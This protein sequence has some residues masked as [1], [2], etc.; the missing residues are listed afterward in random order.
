MKKLSF[1]NV[2]GVLLT[3]LVAALFLNGC[4]EPEGIR[5]YTVAK[6]KNEKR[7]ELPAA[8]TA[9]ADSGPPTD[10]MLG[11]IVPVGDQTWYFKVTGPLA[12]IEKQA[13]AIQKFFGTITVAGGEAKP[14]W[15]KPADW[16][17]HGPSGMRAATLDIPAEPKPLELTVIALPTTGAPNELLDNVNRWRGQMQLPPTDAAALA[18]TVKES[19]AGEA[20]MHIVDLTGKSSGGM[21]AP[22][23]GGGA[24]PPNAPFAGGAGRPPGDPG[25]VANPNATDLPPGHPPITGGAAVDP[26]TAAPLTFDAPASW[27]QQPAMG[28]RKASFQIQDGDRKAEVTAIDLAASAPSIADPLQNVNRWRTTELGLPP[29]TAEQ[30]PALIQKIEVGG[31]PA[32]YVELI[33]DM[34]NPAESQAKEATFAAT[35]PAGRMIWF[36]KLRGHRDL[37][38]AERDNFKAFLNSIRFTSDGGAG[39][40]N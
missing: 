19:K 7:Q 9:P 3:F 2:S 6:E 11:A 28:M 30:L 23:A 8:T 18:A 13:E 34:S 20:T 24:A 10:R 36:F 16:Q 35:V 37:V 27:K 17:E 5:T 29:I 39:N 14:T 4:S 15:E 25:A 40:G 33:P 22:F 1:R 26:A 32:E 21:M 12:E 31:H 38:V